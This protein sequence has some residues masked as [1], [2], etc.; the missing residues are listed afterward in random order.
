MLT[1][2][3]PFPEA[4]YDAMT[5]MLKAPVPFFDAKNN[6]GLKSR[7][8]AMA[9]YPINDTLFLCCYA[10]AGR[11]YALYLIDTLGGREVVYD[12]DQ[13]S[14]AIPILPRRVPRAL[15]SALAEKPGKDEG[16]L[17]V[18]DVYI[19]RHVDEKHPI[20]RGTISALRVNQILTQPTRAHWRL[21]DVS[22]EVMKRPLGTV[23]VNAD[24]SVA[25]AAP[26]GVPLQL[27]ALDTNGMAV[28]TMRSFIYLHR[29]ETQT[30]IGCHENRTTS[31]QNVQEPPVKVHALT[32]VPG[33]DYDDI[34]FSFA[35]TVQ[36]VLDRHCIGC[37]GLGGVPKERRKPHSSY[38]FSVPMD[39]AENSARHDFDTLPSSYKQ[40][41]AALRP[42]LAH[43]N[44]ETF[45]SV[46]RD[47]FS[48][49]SKRMHTLL[50][51]HHGVEL[52]PGSVE[53]LITWLDLNCQCYG[54]YLPNR[55]EQ[56]EPNPAGEAELRAYVKELFGDALASQPLGALVNPADLDES[57]ILCGPLPVR[58]GGW[59]TIDDGFASAHDPRYVRMRTLADKAYKP[60]LYRDLDGTCGHPRCLCG[61]CWIREMVDA[62]VYRKQLELKLA[63]SENPPPRR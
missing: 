31:P 28:M 14:A 37:H 47:Y 35:R 3:I 42:R 43:R 25:L 52:D 51:G 34:G 53:R 36:P 15:S 18:R 4:S 12:K 19:N 2:E 27:Q 23:P 6:K 56:R 5:W 17:V 30:C 58:K 10:A 46:P 13:I 41:V 21:G 59:G 29:G 24:G 57:R 38:V 40:L 45:T 26:A 20:K 49:T 33:V 22:N 16:T 8:T 61:N 32:P 50:A 11:G 60:L 9:P 63:T 1:P 39:E 54:T 62:D 48:P 44:G 55:E 7:A